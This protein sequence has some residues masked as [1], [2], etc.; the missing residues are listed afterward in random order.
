M[1]IKLKNAPK[2]LG[3]DIS[4]KTIGW[5]LFDINSS[6]LLELSHFSPKIKPQP[7]DKIEELIKKAEGFKKHLENYRDVGITKVVIEEPL[8]QSNNIY[9]VGTLLRYNTLILKSCYDVLGILPTFI[10][11]YN[12]RKFAFPSLV[13]KNDKGK[14]VLFGGLPKDIDK[15]HIIWE[16]VN[17]VC[18]EV[19]WLY[20]KTGQLK[21]ENYD[22]S[23][24]ATAVIGYVNMQK[25]VDKD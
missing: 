23:D 12:A 11:T 18:P 5:A 15:K 16:H 19:E 4:T 21:K 10:S 8:L 2:I 6:K 25:N 1:S 20:G 3:L 24:A 14:N 22:M 7:E 17:A 9:T 13:G